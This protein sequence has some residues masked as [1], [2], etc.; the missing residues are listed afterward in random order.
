MFQTC[1]L[2]LPPTSALLTERSKGAEATA[3]LLLFNDTVSFSPWSGLAVS[4]LV[5]AEGWMVEL[6]SWLGWR[7]T[8]LTGFNPF[9]FP[10]PVTRRLLSIIRLSAPATSEMKSAGEKNKFGVHLSVKKKLHH[11]LAKKL[12]SSS[13]FGLTL[14]A[15]S[16]R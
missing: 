7:S 6:T 2:H 8:C 4:L 10:A 9:L 12:I 16:I 15:G 11:F 1:F 3:S 14:C 13:P 5:S